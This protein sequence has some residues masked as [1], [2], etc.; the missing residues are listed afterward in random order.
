[1]NAQSKSPALEPAQLAVLVV[2]VDRLR[3]I[4]DALG[5]P[6]G[7][8]VLT[9]TAARLGA[10]RR[11][12]M[13][14][15]PL[16]A[17]TFSLVLTGLTSR[18]EATAF[19]AEVM[20]ATSAPIVVEDEELLVSVSVGIA[21]G[22]EGPVSARRVTREAA[23]AQHRAQQRGGGCIEVFVAEDSAGLLSML[24]LEG[25][26]RT[27]VAD[28]TGLTLFFQPIISL[29]SG[30]VVAVEAL[31]RWD[32]PVHGLLLPNRFLPL[33][34][35][36]GLLPRI[37]QWALKAACEQLAAWELPRRVCVNVSPAALSDPE[38]V[39][40]VAEH[41]RR[42]SL[43]ADQL[44]IELSEGALLAEQSATRVE[45]LR[46][47]GVEVYLDEFGSGYAW[48]SQLKR[49]PLDGIKL[50]RSLVAELDES[51]TASVVEGVVA[52]ACAL[53]LTVIAKDIETPEQLERVKELGVSAAQGLHFL[54]PVPGRV[55]VE[56]LALSARD[57]AVQAEIG[58]ASSRSKPR[59]A[60]SEEP[61][62][63]LGEAARLLGI[64]A[65]TLRRWTEDGRVSAVRTTGGHRRF[66]V[67]E[68][69]R[70]HST[71]AA[72]LR[73]PALPDRALPEIADILRSDGI[74]LA[75]SVA[76]S[77]YEDRLGWFG[78]EEALAPTRAW[79]GEL[80]SG[81]GE[82]AYETLGDSLRRFM[83][84]AEVGGAAL[85]ERYVFLDRFGPALERH[86]NRRDRPH[87]EQAAAR[88]TFG[89]LALE[90]LA[91]DAD[92]HG[93][94]RPRARARRSRGSSSLASL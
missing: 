84:R 90:Q 25:D 57:P 17:D 83:L 72:Q 7:D 45:E 85:A 67:S 10:L 28:E 74:E 21:F 40:A 68:L 73:V 60:R 76:R 37:E 92:S 41:L 51:G 56:V 36:T 55:L 34:Q 52:S 88:R 44:I 87:S 91:D 14:L 32:H 19:A 86:L 42:Y 15:T 62:V 27:A 11:D 65:S 24:R 75:R 54:A 81:F 30:A 12:G 31:V 89:A 94:T 9:A 63:T 69:A 13:T 43:D 35:R 47:L 26:L 39:P 46:A 61:A 79:L 2:G 82:G 4:T 48:L 80:A 20:T 66:Y 70:L 53:G 6:A 93:P 78:H 38:F 64:S 8:Q 33:A 5:P 71:N 58:P 16:I 3:E 22:T 77:M 18:E 23:T 29:A 50:S 1:M 59:E 49:L